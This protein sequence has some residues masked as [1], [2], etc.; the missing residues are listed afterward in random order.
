[1]AGEYWGQSWQPWVILLFL[2]LSC[3]QAGHSGQN[4]QAAWMPSGSSGYCQEGDSHCPPPVLS[5]YFIVVVVV[6]VSIH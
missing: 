4:P 2:H 6:V 5:P 3:Y 1:M